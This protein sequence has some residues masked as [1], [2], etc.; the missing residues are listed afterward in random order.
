MV[1]CACPCLDAK[2]C[3]ARR[4]GRD[5]RF[6]LDGDDYADDPGFDGCACSCHEVVLDEESFDDGEG[7]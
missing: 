2:D 7:A 1:T 3:A 4:T 6:L 5:L